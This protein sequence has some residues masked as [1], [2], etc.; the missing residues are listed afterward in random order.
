MTDY[1]LCNSV[2]VKLFPINRAGRK[3]KHCSTIIQSQV[4]LES[5]SAAEIPFVRTNNG[6]EHSI[7]G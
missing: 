1:C 4:A 2:I 6:A 5:D 3:R 7:P